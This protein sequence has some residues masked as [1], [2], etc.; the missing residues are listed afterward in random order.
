[1]GA[2]RRP[3]SGTGPVWIFDLD[4]TLHDANVHIFPHL[5]HS[6]TAYL[7]RYL[8]LDRD[9]ANALRVQYWRR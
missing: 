5:N 1:M 3:R 9:G 6:M 7:Q 4:N 8:G 2:R